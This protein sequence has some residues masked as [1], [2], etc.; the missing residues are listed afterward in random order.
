MKNIN[1]IEFY[2]DNFSMKDYEYLEIFKFDN[3]PFFILE[4]IRETKIR[5][6][7]QI[8]SYNDMIL[9][10]RY[11]NSCIYRLKN[12]SYVS[13]DFL[14]KLYKF[15]LYNWVLH[16]E[17]LILEIKLLISILNQSCDY[18]RQIVLINNII[19]KLQQFINIAKNKMK[20]Q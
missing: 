6:R 16:D 9:Y 19:N 13:N 4:Y 14:K 1:I 5:C 11:I 20:L 8:I 17:Y 10:I 12:K 2:M 15:L 18:D 3:Q 7:L